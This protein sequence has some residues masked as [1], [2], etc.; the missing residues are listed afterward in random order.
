[1]IDSH[2]SFLA[3]E[4]E[5][6][7]KSFD[8]KLQTSAISLF[9]R[10][11]IFVGMFLGVSNGQMLLKIRTKRGLP[12]KNDYFLGIVIGAKHHIYSNYQNWAD[13]NYYDLI[14]KNENTT[15]LKS[16]WYDT[17]DTNFSR[18]AF[19][20][21][22]CDFIDDLKPGCIVI[23]GPNKPP[24]EY[25]SSLV[26]YKLKEK[27][28]IPLSPNN[29]K[30][31]SLCNKSSVFDK[32]KAQLN[33]DNRMI[34]LGPP[35]TGKSY[36]IAELISYYLKQNK[37]VLSTALTNRALIELAT[38]EPLANEMTLGKLHK[39][40]LS[41]DEAHEVKQLNSLEKISPVVGELHLATFYSI[42]KIWK[43]LSDNKY[44][45]VIV[46]EASQAFLAFLQIV[47]NI[48]KTVIFVG[49]IEQL[50]PIISQNKDDISSDQHIYY[51]GLD[52][53]LRY[54]AIP[55]YMLTYTHRLSEDSAR[56]TSLFY[57]E[58]IK[59]II[60]K[61]NYFRFTSLPFIGEF[62]PEKGGVVWIKSSLSKGSSP[63]EGVHL[64]GDILELFSKE[65]ILKEYR[66]AVLSYFKKTIQSIGIE[67]NKRSVNTNKLLLDTVSRVQG[68]TRDVCIY[69][70][71]KDRYSYSCERHLFNVATSRA[72]M[73]TIIIT[74][75]QILDEISNPVVIKYFKS[76]KYILDTN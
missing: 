66:I 11:E 4:L 29:Y 12:R 28:N 7:T 76:I 32:L 65:M 62:L 18:I 22:T 33:L 37:S 55:S 25:L 59:S 9:Q 19:S 71:T 27:D 54:E 1:M 6:V 46:D 47:M 44:D 34:I 58:N 17:I 48:G 75:N 35:G 26:S 70:I 41:E 68:E 5:A 21:A 50:P 8:M 16:V 42:S 63:I 43:E 57:P 72:K 60:S 15:E 56:L 69:F 10:N 3:N 20:R 73:Y 14:K 24:L 13:L 23:L 30:P 2:Y 31:I 45:L 36:L 38:K 49:D 53:L 74:D 67:L 52:T 51:K 64:I 61:Q 40:N 39:I